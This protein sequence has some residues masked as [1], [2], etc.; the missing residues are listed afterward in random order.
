MRARSNTLAFV[1][2]AKDDR[3][4]TMKKNKKT[5]FLRPKSSVFLEGLTAGLPIAAGYFAVS[6]A[7]GV[8]AKNAGLNPFEGFLASMLTNASAGEYAGFLMIAANATYIEFALM[9]LVANARYFLMSCALSQ[10]FSPATR[11]FHR[12]II[13]FDITDEIFGITIARPGYIVPAYTYGAMLVAIPAWA[14][15]TA[16]G[17]VAGN[18]LPVRLVSALGVA[19]YGMFLAIIIPPARK[20]RACAFAVLLS[21]A[22]SLVASLIPALSFLSDGTKTLILT[23]LISS[24]AAILFPRK[25]EGEGGD[26]R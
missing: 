12:L 18:I 8:S 9:I 17:I 6:F 2:A 25:E 3:Y 1:T 23:I 19:L 14:S 13:G 21:F 22:A 26:E 20:D 11:F 5:E 7:L 15:G 24:L 16:L 4:K 10:K